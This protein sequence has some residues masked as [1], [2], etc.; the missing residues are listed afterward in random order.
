MEY[1]NQI[2]IIQRDVDLITEEIKD[3]KTKRDEKNL[4]INFAKKFPKEILKAKRNA[5]IEG[6]QV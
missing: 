5:L 2:S 3:R 1:E 4:A 6:E